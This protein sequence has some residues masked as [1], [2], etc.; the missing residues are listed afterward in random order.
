MNR[1][2]TAV[3]LVGLALVFA[4]INLTDNFLK[5][6]FGEAVGLTLVFVAICTAAI[7][8]LLRLLECPH[9]EKSKTGINAGKLTPHGR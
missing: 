4:R 9:E 3:I 5:T 8:G 7:G 1:T 2:S 6:Q